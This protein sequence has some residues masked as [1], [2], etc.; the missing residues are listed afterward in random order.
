MAFVPQVDGF[1]AGLPTTSLAE[2]IDVCE[3]FGTGP[4]LLE[5][6]CVWSNRAVWRLTRRQSKQ[7]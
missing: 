2:A 6:V 5:V 4:S 3:S 7:A 1:V